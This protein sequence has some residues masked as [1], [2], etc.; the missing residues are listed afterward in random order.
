[1]ARRELVRCWEGGTKKPTERVSRR[2]WTSLWRCRVITANMPFGC[3]EVRARRRNKQNRIPRGRIYGEAVLQALDRAV[4]GRGSDLW[5]ASK[6]AAAGPD[7]SYGTTRTSATGPEVR[8]RLLTVSA[9]TIDRLLSGVRE[10]GKQRRSG[11]PPLCEKR[12]RSE[13]S[14]TG[15]IRLRE[16]WKRILFVTVVEQ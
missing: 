12:Y 9:A 4:G 1:M 11:I 10:K 2:F 16:I 15:R 7:R 14:A 5:Q 6:G 13:H 8:S 3:W